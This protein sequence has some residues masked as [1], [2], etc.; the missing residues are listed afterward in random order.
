MHDLEAAYDGG[1]GR[2]RLPVDRR[3]V[4]AQLAGP[5]AG[6][7]DAERQ[8]APAGGPAELDDRR[9]HRRGDQQLTG[10]ADG[11]PAVSGEQAHPVDERD[12]PLEPVLGQQ[13]RDAEV[14]DQPG[15]RRE[16]L[17]GRGRVE[18]GGRLVEHEQSRVHGQHRPDRHPLLLAAGQ[19]PQ[20]A[21]AQ[22]RDAEQVE[23]LFDPATHRL[24]RQPELLH[25]VGEL[26]LDGVGDEA[27]GGVLPDVADR[28]GPLPRRR[29]HDADAVEQHVAVE[30]AAREA[31]DQ[32][33]DDAEQR[34]LPDARRAGHQ[35]QLALVD[36]QVDVA[37]HG[38]GVVVPEADVTQLD[39]AATSS[40]VGT[41]TAGRDCC[42]EHSGPSSATAPAASA[43]ALSVGK[44]SSGG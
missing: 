14:V 33:G 43:T 29:A 9:H 34:R 6:V 20:V 44:A 2:R 38:A 25:A 37:Q 24:G 42:G 23:R 21:V 1:G 10:L 27:G 17:L 3:R 36:D 22:V 39:H 35:H 19:R 30:R 12:H 13:H 8:R 18:G 11:D 26:L 31:R 5:A 16:H 28:V 7:A 41:T 15:Q 32:P 40:R 4:E